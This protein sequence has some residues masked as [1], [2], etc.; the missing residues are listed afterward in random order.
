MSA[1]VEHL[2]SLGIEVAQLDETIAGEV[3]DV[4]AWLSSHG[5]RI[6]P[7]ILQDLRRRRLGPRA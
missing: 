7:S 5:Y 6:S 3:Q 2:G 4:S 1:F